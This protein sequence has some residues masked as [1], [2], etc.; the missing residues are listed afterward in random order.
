MGAGRGDRNMQI[1][2]TPRGLYATLE[3]VKK[4]TSSY[5]STGKELMDMIVLRAVE[6]ITARH[7]ENLTTAAQKP[8]MP[9]RSPG[10]R[11]AGT[12]FDATA[13]V[14]I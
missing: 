10:Y 7:G 12:Y 14:F 5:A 8:P 13:L 1:S 11:R 4:R 2:R 3:S 9:R 6:R